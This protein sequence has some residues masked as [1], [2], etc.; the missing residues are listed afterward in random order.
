MKAIRECLRW[1]KDQESRLIHPGYELEKHGQRK[2]DS[3][4][5][6]NGSHLPLYSV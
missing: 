6:F 4:S 2:D 1:D 3:L 5:V